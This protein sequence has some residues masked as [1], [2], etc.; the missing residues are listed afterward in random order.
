MIT[1]QALA[2]LAFNGRFATAADAP[3]LTAREIETADV[4]RGIE[5]RRIRRAAG[6][7]YLAQI[8]SR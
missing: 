2:Q 3:Q 7:A 4:Q 1:E 8:W 5:L 6:L